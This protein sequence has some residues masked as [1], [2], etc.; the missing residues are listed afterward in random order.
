MHALGQILVSLNTVILF[1]TKYLCIQKE[2]V[3]ILFMNV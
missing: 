1:I 2:V 3:P